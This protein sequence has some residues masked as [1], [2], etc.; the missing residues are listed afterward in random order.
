MK[1]C[2]KCGVT[3]PLTEFSKS[4]NKKCGV[5]GWCKK[6]SAEAQKKRYKDNPEIKKEYYEKHEE[7]IKAYRRLPTSRKTRAVGQKNYCKINK[8]TW[9]DLIPA[10]TQCQVC[11][12]D[13]FFQCNDK[14]RAIH[15]DHRNGGNEAIKLSPTVWLQS[16]K[17][18]PSNEVIWKS[19]DFGMLCG[20]CN[21]RLPTLDRKQF[22]NNITRYINHQE[23]E[24]S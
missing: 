14:R 11:G 7:H 2:P 24:I 21:Q 4:R 10:I 1:R 18:T 22:L 12:K 8:D 13:I 20:Q 5:A 3:K 9:K 15:F 17:R 19:C 23:K 16:H 6:C